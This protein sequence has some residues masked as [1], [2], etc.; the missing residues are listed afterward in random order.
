[1]RRATRLDAQLDLGEVLAAAGRID[2]A[3]AGLRARARTSR[4]AKGGVVTPRRRA[5]PTRGARRRP[6]RSR[7]LSSP[8]PRPVRRRRRDDRPDLGF[9]LAAVIETTQPFEFRLDRAYRQLSPL[10]EDFVICDRRL[11]ASV[12]RVERPGRRASPVRRARRPRPGGRGRSSYRAPRCRP[13]C[14]MRVAGRLG[15]RRRVTEVGPPRGIKNDGKQ[16]FDDDRVRRPR[17]RA[18][19]GSRPTRSAR[20]GA[21]S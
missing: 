17:R 19:S 15:D 11:A 6:A 7:I 9:P 13:R 12:G 1:M 20:V 2:E 4:S 8:V 18:S 21:V 16:T 10:C 5:P 14:P 3:R